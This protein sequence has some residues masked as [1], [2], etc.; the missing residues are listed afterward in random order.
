M[1]LARALS[2]ARTRPPIPANIK[3]SSLRHSPGPPSKSQSPIPGNQNLDCLSVPHPGEAP[4]PTPSAA[5]KST[6][7]RGPSARCL[8]AGRRPLAQPP[9]RAA[10]P[11]K[12]NVPKP[13]SRPQAARSAAR[14]AL[15]AGR[16]ALGAWGGA[17]DKYVFGPLWL[18]CPKGTKGAQKSPVKFNLL[19]PF[20]TIR[21]RL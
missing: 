5:R 19:G 14:R 18:H 9:A 15:L 8:R 12:A 13:P 16:S 17:P 3:C 10:P 1:Q 21:E 20:I 7:R 11:A 2:H 4:D 6:P